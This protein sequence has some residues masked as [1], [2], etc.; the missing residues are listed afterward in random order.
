MTFLTSLAKILFKR[1]K[2]N[3]LWE[4]R[5]LESHFQIFLSL[6]S[7]VVEEFERSSSY[8][9]LVLSPDVIKDFRLM[10]NHFY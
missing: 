1:P 8:I 2:F 4:N 5:T 6:K 9:S 10:D 7:K 3:I